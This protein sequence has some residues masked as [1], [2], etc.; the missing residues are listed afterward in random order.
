[1]RE[2]VVGRFLWRLYFEKARRR[3]LLIFLVELVEL[4]NVMRRQADVEEA[5]MALMAVYQRGLGRRTF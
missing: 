1:V 4:P 3:D 2:E 5:T